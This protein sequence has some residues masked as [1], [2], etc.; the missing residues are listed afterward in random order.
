MD[1]CGTVIKAYAKPQTTACHGV[2]HGISMRKS[3]QIVRQAGR[4]A[5]WAWAAQW[6]TYVSDFSRSSTLFVLGA[7]TTCRTLLFRAHRHRT[8]LMSRI[9]HTCC[10]HSLRIGIAS[11]R[12]PHSAAA[13]WRRW[14]AAGFDIIAR[15][16]W[17]RRDRVE[18]FIDAIM[19]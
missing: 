18:T 14:Y 5:A 6:T 4:L 15:R 11:R 9:L 8:A 12:R 3:W 10:L 17:R 2:C 1:F 16:R 13:G 7:T 19:G